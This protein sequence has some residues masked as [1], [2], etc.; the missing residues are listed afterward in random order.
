MINV[1]E[2]GLAHVQGVTNLHPAEGGTDQET[3]AHAKQRGPWELKHG[4]RAVTREDF[5]QLARKASPLVGA[6]DCYVENGV[7]QVIIVPND[8]QEKPQPNQRL[9]RDVEAY[10]N[11]RRLINTRLEVRGPE[12]EAVDVEIQVALDPFYVGRFSELKPQLEERLRTFVH[13]LTGLGGGG[14]PMGR[15]LHISELSYRLE[16]VAGVDHVEKLTIRKSGTTQPQDRVVVADLSFPCFS[17]LMKI[18][19]VL[20]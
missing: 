14:W 9:I 15:A 18:S 8:P 2:S 20:G 13:P 5:I 12:Y 10:L 11:A 4:D 16:G 3:I 19:Q 1:L 7:V 6:A 17:P